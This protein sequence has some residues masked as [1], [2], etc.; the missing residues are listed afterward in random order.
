MHHEVV[1]DAQFVA[2]AV[3]PGTILGRQDLLGPQH[4][5]QREWIEKVQSMTVDGGDVVVAED[6]GR[7]ALANQRDALIRVRAVADDVAEAQQPVAG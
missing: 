2:Q 1:G 6:A 7:R 4:R 3:E 5:F